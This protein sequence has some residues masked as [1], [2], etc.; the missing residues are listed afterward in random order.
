MPG[1]GQGRVDKVGESGIYPVSAMEGASDDAVI[2]DEASFG[3]GESGAY[4]SNKNKEKKN[5]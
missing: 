5:D 1:D 2:H 4:Q 3:Q